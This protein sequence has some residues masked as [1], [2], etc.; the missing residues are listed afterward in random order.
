MFNNYN[1]NSKRSLPEDL[2]LKALPFVK[3]KELVGKTLNVDGFFFTNGEYGKQV[4]VVANGLKINFPNRYIETFESI[5]ANDEELEAVLKG[6]LGI[7]D[8]K[9]VKAK[10]GKTVTCTLYDID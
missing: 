7:K 1:K 10:K 9:E 2:D 6:K 8:I 5:L 3:L 4:V